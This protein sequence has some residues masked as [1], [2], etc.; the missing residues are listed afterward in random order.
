MNKNSLKDEVAVVTG[1]G[2]GIGFETA[3]TLAW[4]GAKVVTSEINDPNGKAAE[5]TLN[6]EFG[7]GTAFFVRTDV[8]DEKT[9]MIWLMSH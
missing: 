9:L 1:A 4:L 6:K 7:K 3:K 2:R 5:E 8:G